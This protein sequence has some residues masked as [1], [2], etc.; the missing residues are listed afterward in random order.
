MSRPWTLEGLTALYALSAAG[1]DLKAS[2]EALDR[3]SGDCDRA[4]WALFGRT[5]HQALDVLNSG[6]SAE[7]EPV[8]LQDPPRRGSTVGRFLRRMFP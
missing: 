5:P 2:A 1:A 8:T 7:L 6:P 4:L 3:F